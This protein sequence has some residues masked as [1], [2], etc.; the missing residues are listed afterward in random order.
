VSPATLFRYYAT[1][2]DIVL[3]DVYDPLIAEA[4]R[5]R[6]AA[7]A[8]LTAVRSGFAEAFAGVCQAELEVIRQRTALIL[9]VSALRARSRE[10]QD[11]LQVHLADALA[12]R[13][14]RSGGEL[15]I[16]VAA[17]ACTA[18]V[19]VA[20]ERWAAEGGSLPHHVDTALAAVGELASR[21]HR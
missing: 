1:K 21:R 16:Q 19:S 4:V 14:G 17:A 6:P 10:Q 9:S 8:F 12:Q 2:E 15:G 20:V 18:A 3:Q 13:S 11:V 5:A 7:E